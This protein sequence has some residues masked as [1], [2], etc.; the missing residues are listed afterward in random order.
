MRFIFYAVICSFIS[1][2][3]VNA[4]CIQPTNLQHQ[5]DIPVQFP[6]LQHNM[7]AK[8]DTAASKPYLYVAGKERGL[9]IYNISNLKAEDIKLVEELEREEEIIHNIENEEHCKIGHDDVFMHRSKIK[10]KLTESD[11]N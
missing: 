8:R 4:Q 2:Q 5:V 10:E 1:I 9:V 11:S 7:T 3:F 6:L